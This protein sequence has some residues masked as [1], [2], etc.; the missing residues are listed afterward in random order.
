MAKCGLDEVN[1]FEDMSGVNH[2]SPNAKLCT[3]VF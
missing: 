1:N 2:A 3:L